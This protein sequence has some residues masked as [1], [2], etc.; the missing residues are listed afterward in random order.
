MPSPD[1]GTRVSTEGSDKPVP[2]PATSVAPKTS[3]P[4]KPQEPAVQGQTSETKKPSKRKVQPWAI[5]AAVA[6]SVAI[7]LAIVLIARSDS[8]AESAV[9]ESVTSVEV[10]NSAS[11]TNPDSTPTT[12]EPTDRSLEADLSR[13]QASLND[14]DAKVRDLENQL[15]DSN[16]LLAVSQSVESELTTELEEARSRVL[17]LQSDSAVVPGVTLAAVRNRGHLNCGVSGTTLGFSE[18]QGNGDMVG[19]DADYCRAIAAAVLGDSE[20]VRFV[21]L[22]AAERFSSLRSDEIDV[23]I[24]TTTWTQSRDTGMDLQFGPTT[25]YDGQQLMGNPATFSGL[26][27]DSEFSAIDGAVVC[28]FPDSTVRRNLMDSAAA[29][30]VSITFELVDTISEAMDVFV[31]GD[32][33]IV[34]LGGARLHAERAKGVAAGTSGASRWVI[35]PKDRISREPLGPVVREGDENWLDVVQWTVFSTVIA[36]ARGV[37]SS[38][39][40]SVGPGD[41]EMARLFGGEDES[42]TA[43]GLSRDAFYEVIRQVGNYDE[44][45]SRNLARILDMERDGTPNELWSAGG[46]LIAPPAR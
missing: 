5:G 46:L 36:E 26:S 1:P 11:G 7:V 28:T 21:A 33:D 13:V 10:T 44:I 8:G 45:Y 27:A 12:G 3:A 17:A 22:T 16:E 39:V 23:L 20:A 42:Q 34:A 40:D 38:N 24:R 32:C 31:T 43:M 4:P 35:F 14:S 29:A 9:Q 15:Q 25:F 30:N 2:D 6:A 19:F 18:E 37:S 41:G